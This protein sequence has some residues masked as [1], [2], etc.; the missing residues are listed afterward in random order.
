ML[1]AHDAE[2]GE[3]RVKGLAPGG[4]GAQ[5]LS[6]ENTFNLKPSGDDIYYTD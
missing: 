5:V 6:Y 3:V 2:T 4:A 1:L